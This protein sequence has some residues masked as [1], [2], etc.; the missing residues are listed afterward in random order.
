MLPHPIFLGVSLSVSGIHPRGRSEEMSF[1][2]KLM[3][4]TS[5]AGS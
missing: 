5:S 3:Y 4:S 2:T 1:I